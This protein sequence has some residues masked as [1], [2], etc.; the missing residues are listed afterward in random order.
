MFRDWVEHHFFQYVL[1]L[2]V[3]GVMLGIFGIY[4]ISII[5]SAHDIMVFVFESAMTG[6]S[7]G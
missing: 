1:L 2:V 4:L 7:V 3:M 6:G 5:L